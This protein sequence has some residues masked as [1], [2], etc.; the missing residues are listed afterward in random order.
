LILRKE[1]TKTTV[2]AAVKLRDQKKREAGLADGDNKD[3]VAGQNPEL[4][5]PKYVP[6]KHREKQAGMLAAQKRI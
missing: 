5:E 1:E 4:V 2:D 3:F 6:K